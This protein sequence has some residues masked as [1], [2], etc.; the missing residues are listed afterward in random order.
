MKDSHGRIIGHFDQHFTTYV[1]WEDNLGIHSQSV[2]RLASDKSF[3]HKLSK[4]DAFLLGYL[5]GSTHERMASIE[6]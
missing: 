1:I 5:L 3:I 6:T 4:E 2:T